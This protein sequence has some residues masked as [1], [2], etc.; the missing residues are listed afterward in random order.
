MGELKNSQTT[1]YDQRSI[2]ER[3]EWME[4]WAKASKQYLEP[5]VV[6]RSLKS[7]QGVARSGLRPPRQVSRH[8]GS[9]QHDS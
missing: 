6:K 8:K 1:K 5:P 7:W 3:K 2:K 4:H 9:G